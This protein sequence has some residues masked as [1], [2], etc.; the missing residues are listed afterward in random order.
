MNITD[1]AR[2]PWV[3]KRPIDWMLRG[4]LAVNVALFVLS[5]FPAFSGLGP[6]PGWA[7]RLW[8]NYRLGSWR[9]DFVWMCM[10]TVLLSVAGLPRTRDRSARTTTRMLCWAWLACFAIYLCYTLLHMFG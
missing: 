10:S 8:G 4:V 1:T 9:A 5:F 2:S 7:D 3:A 6:T